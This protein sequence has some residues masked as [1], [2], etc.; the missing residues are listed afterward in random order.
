MLEN[1]TA[2][3]LQGVTSQEKMKARGI[4]ALKTDDRSIRM[5]SHP[6]VSDGQI[7][8]ACDIVANL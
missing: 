5:V 1:K 6:D 7:R 8:E 3:I 2:L 4:P